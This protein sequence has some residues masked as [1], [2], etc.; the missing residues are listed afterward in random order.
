MPPIDMSL[1]CCQLSLEIHKL[2]IHKFEV[3][4]ASSNITHGQLECVSKVFDGMAEKKLVVFLGFLTTGSVLLGSKN[5]SYRNWLVV[6]I[7]CAMA[8]RTYFL[9]IKGY[10]HKEKRK[11][12]VI[13]GYTF[14]KLCFSVRE[15]TVA[16]MG[17][18]DSTVIRSRG[19]YQLRV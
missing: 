4:P 9:L 19:S 15:K 18:L 3:M 16:N 8:T 14:W 6:G 11:N 12:G 17:T 10:F 7:G 13:M 1:F 5:R 2:E